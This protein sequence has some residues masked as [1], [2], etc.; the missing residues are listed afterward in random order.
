MGSSGQP[1]WKKVSS[2][3]PPGTLKRLVREHFVEESEDPPIS[4]VGELWASTLPDLCPREEVLCDLLQVVRKRKVDPDLGLIFL[5]GKALHWALQTHLLPKI[6]A[7]YGRWSCGA[8]GLAVGD[9]HNL[10]PRPVVCADSACPSQKYKRREF[11]YHELRYFDE[12]HRIVVRPDGFLK[13]APY[14]DFGVLEAKSIGKAWEVRQTPNVGHVIQAQIAM[15]QADCSWG[16]ILYWEKGAQGTEALIEH[17]IERDEDTIEQVK[18]V[19]RSIWEGIQHRSL[20]ARVCAVANA[21]RSQG[22]VVAK[23][24]FATE[25]AVLTPE[26][27]SGFMSL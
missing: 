16:K 19:A 5:H 18:Q 10:Q 21:P 17:H 1:V 12:K 15:W 7:L 22:C 27:I 2:T 8:C 26:D 14:P 4:Q 24:C 6:S 3:P 25:K 20:P 9:K 23:P 11:H 13:I